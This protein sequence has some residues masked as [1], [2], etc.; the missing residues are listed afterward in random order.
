MSYFLIIGFT[1]G[2]RHAFDADHLAAVTTLILGRPS[3]RDSVRIGV[4]WGAGHALMLLAATCV[5]LLGGAEIN[6]RYAALFESLAGVM[7]I[8]LGF[9]VLRRAAATG[10]HGHGHRH[11]GAPL[12]VHFHRHDVAAVAHDADPHRH[13]HAPL[14]FGR[15]LAVGV[16]HGLAG[17]A[18]LILLSA[19][20]T[21]SL[22]TAILYVVCFGAGTLA[23]MALV[24]ALLAVPFRYCATAYPQRLKLAHA[25]AGAVSVAVGAWLVL[26][27]VLAER[28]APLI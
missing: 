21:P 25:A 11:E 3:R 14:T 17:S 24:S 16:V 23:G 9:D 8:V 19:A 27:P 2:I 13:A 18:A 5:V 26:A 4:A 10:L 7:L 15:A 1:L 20:T 28:V 22:P 6:A 12:H